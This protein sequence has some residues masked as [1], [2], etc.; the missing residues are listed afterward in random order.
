MKIFDQPQ[1]F[2]PSLFHI[3]E[4]LREFGITEVDELVAGVAYPEKFPPSDASYPDD[5]TNENMRAPELTVRSLVKVGQFLKIFEEDPKQIQIT[6]Q[7]TKE[8]EFS[9][10]W[11]EVRSCV[12]INGMGDDENQKQSLPVA[13]A[14]YL[15]FSLGATP[16]NWETAADQLAIDFASSENEKINRSWIVPNSTQWVPFVRWLTIL[17]FAREL[18][19]QGNGKSILVPDIS[20]ALLPTVNRLPQN[21]SVSIGD[22]ITMMIDDLPCFE[23]GYVWERLPEIAKGRSKWSSDVVLAGLRTL[24][25]KGIIELVSVKDSSSA[26]PFGAKGEPLDQVRK[27]YLS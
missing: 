21:Q 18:P 9:A 4:Y 3:W 26:T 16:Q 20:R 11:H 17:G 24:E 1:N 14:W 23:G 27:V 19:V 25:S 2:P 22:F 12:F 8:L 15:S 7:F 10:F 5:S 6:E 13:I